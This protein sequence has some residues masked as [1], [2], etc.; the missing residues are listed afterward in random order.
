MYISQHYFGQHEGHLR[1]EANDIAKES[2]AWHVNYTDPCT[3]LKRGWFATSTVD[4]T[5]S[6]AVEQNVMR[7]VMAV[8]GFKALR[9]PQARDRVGK[10]KFLAIVPLPSEAHDSAGASTAPISQ[11]CA[12]EE[13]PARRAA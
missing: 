13:Q 12:T 11:L 4:G 6:G 9:K 5:N 3:G 7:K 1:E 2:G 8:G 10:E